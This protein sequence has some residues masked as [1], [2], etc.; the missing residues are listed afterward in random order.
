MLVTSLFLLPERD[1]V[2]LPVAFQ[3]GGGGES[4]TFEGPH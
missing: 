3:L 4:L 1:P 2:G